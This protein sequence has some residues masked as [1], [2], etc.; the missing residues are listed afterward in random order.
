MTATAAHPRSAG[1]SALRVRLGRHPVSLLLHR[2]SAAVACVLLAVLAVLMLASA[3]LGQT[4]VT[5]YDVWHVL[6]GGDGPYALV[7]GELR[8]PRIA[9]GAL[10]GAALGAAGALV[11][12]VTRNPLA[13]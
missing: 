11:Q 13:S 1:L 2:R 8:V 4:V 7:V 3:C 6:R 12:S 5:P 10:V 9:L